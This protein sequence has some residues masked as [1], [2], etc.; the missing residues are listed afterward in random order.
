MSDKDAPAGMDKRQVIKSGDLDVGVHRMWGP[1]IAKYVVPEDVVKKANALVDKYQKN[2]QK[3]KQNDYAYNLAGEISQE[4]MPTG[5]ELAEI[6]LAEHMLKAVEMMVRG[7]VPEMDSNKLRIGFID[8]WFVIQ[9]AGDW[10]PPHYHGGQL[11]AALWLDT[12]EG[13]A[14][15][16]RKW[17]GGEFVFVAPCTPT[18]WEQPVVHFEPVPGMMVVFPAYLTHAVAPHMA[19]GERRSFAF[20]C[21]LGFEVN[22]EVVPFEGIYPG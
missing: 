21:N 19:E 18:E 6:G 8:C 10:N 17:G 12:P 15:S 9:K 20:N 4:F 2:D 16:T 14:T 7:K 11:S 3:R 1:P 22:G 13:M 5:D